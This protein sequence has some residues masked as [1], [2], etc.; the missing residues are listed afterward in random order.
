MHMAHQEK[1]EGKRGEGSKPVSGQIEGEQSRADCLQR[2]RTEAVGGR[3]AGH[4]RPCR[5]AAQGRACLSRHT[6]PWDSP[7]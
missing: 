6:V 3:G 5:A 7:A 4:G 2:A 1:G